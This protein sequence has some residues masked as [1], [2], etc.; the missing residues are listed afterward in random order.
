MEKKLFWL[1]LPFNDFF[2]FVCS[3]LRTSIETFDFYLS[4]ETFKCILFF[5]IWKTDMLDKVRCLFI[6]LN[7][8]SLSSNYITFVIQMSKWQ[9]WHSNHLNHNFCLYFYFLVF[10]FLRSELFAI[11]SVEWNHNNDVL[12]LC[13]HFNNNFHWNKA[14]EWFF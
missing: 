4:K 7:W 13:T 1:M 3:S 14:K 10:N 6:I 12:C 5:P 11:K 8:F 9:F 2:Y